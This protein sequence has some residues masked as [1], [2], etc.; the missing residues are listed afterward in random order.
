MNMTAGIIAVGAH[1]TG[2]RDR[3]LHTMEAI[4]ATTL[5]DE[6]AALFLEALP[7][8]PIRNLWM[9]VSFGIADQKVCKSIPI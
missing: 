1:Q 3:C 8:G 6:L 4:E 5:R 9:L 2:L 7:D